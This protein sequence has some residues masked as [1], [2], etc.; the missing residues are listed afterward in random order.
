MNDKNKLGKHLLVRPLG[1]RTLERHDF[2]ASE[3][4]GQAFACDERNNLIE[5]AATAEVLE[6]KTTWEDVSSYS[7]RQ[8]KSS[9]IGGLMGAITFDGN[10]RPLLPLL[11]WA[12]VLHADKYT[13]KGNTPAPKPE[14]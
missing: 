8:G 6:D 7:R 12:M 5:L 4:G 2:L 11:A 9:P 10:H 13:T 14:H 1:E 3:Y